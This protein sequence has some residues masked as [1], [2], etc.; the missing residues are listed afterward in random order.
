MTISA[1]TVRSHSVGVLLAAG[2]GRRFGGAYPGA[3]LD[4]LIDGVSVGARS[5]NTL[6]TACGEV[7]VVVRDAD[8]LLAR[9]AAARGATVIINEAPQ[10]GMGHSLALAAKYALTLPKNRH[11]MWATLAD[12]PYLNV[13]TISEL[14][15]HLLDESADRCS[16]IVQPVY[17][18]IEA[19]NSTVQHGAKLTNSRADAQPGHPVIFGRAHWAALAA[20]TGDSGARAVIQSNREHV[21][22]VPISDSGI[23][24]DI[25][26]PSDLL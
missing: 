20:L 25:D 11:F 10:Q 13:L 15:P 22:R 19:Q 24:R 7:I 17:V 14:A 1:E 6:A 5:F 3:K 23:V 8:A 4:Q 21:V 26:S 12:L 18:P 16:A 2:E 9:H